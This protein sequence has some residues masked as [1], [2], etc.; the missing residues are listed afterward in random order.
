MVRQVVTGVHMGGI[1]T[2]VV[3]VIVSSVP[4]GGRWQLMVP[5]RVPHV[6]LGLLAKSV[7]RLVTIARLG[8]I[9]LIQQET[10]TGTNVVRVVMGST[11]LTML[12]LGVRT[13]RLVGTPTHMPW[14]LV[15]HVLL[16]STKTH[17]EAPLAKIAPKGGD[18]I[19]LGRQCA[20]N[21]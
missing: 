17:L 2:K 15:R 14:G 13:A 3:R 12:D 1:S 16:G 7:T 19:L 21:V 10:L 6:G 8:I 18:K 20:R 4:K 11:S 9:L 5:H